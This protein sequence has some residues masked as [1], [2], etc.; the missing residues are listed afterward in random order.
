MSK[1]LNRREM[2]V[3]FQFLIDRFQ[4]DKKRLPF[5][6]EDLKDFFQRRE[7]P[8]DLSMFYFLKIIP[9]SRT[10]VRIDYSVKKTP[11]KFYMR[12]EYLY[13]SIEITGSGKESTKESEFFPRPKF[14]EF[15]LK[16]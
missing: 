10:T 9:I 4:R 16:F 1:T 15:L 14:E 5:H 7:N 12:T 3:M 2:A 8:L 6:S 13:E 11:S